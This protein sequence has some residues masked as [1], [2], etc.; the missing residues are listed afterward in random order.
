VAD[1]AHSDSETSVCS[2]KRDKSSE[3]IAKEKHA[4]KKKKKKKLQSWNTHCW[5]SVCF[6]S[7]S[8]FLSERE[9]E[10]H[11][12]RGGKMHEERR[13]G[14]GLSTDAEFKRFSGP[15]VKREPPG[16]PL[17]DPG[18]HRAPHHRNRDTLGTSET[19]RWER[20]LFCCG[21]GGGEKS[22]PP[23]ISNAVL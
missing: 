16:V 15:R 7:C 13:G 14:G 17:V 19:S 21:V 18:W 8:G 6:S 20:L 1:K 3:E 5:D 12:R 23:L 2:G 11:E 9:K 4:E 22:T 10:K